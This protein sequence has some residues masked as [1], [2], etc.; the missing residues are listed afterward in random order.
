MQSVKMHAQSN[1]DKL[2]MLKLLY[3]FEETAFA[4]FSEN[5]TAQNTLTHPSNEQFKL[6]LK[7][8]LGAFQNPF[9]EAGLWIRG[10]M[11]DIQGMINALKSRDN[12]VQA[13]RQCE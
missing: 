6:G 13:Q 7:D 1:Q 12:I 5:D 9:R 4:Y 3:R 2:E 10:E 11:L 8:R